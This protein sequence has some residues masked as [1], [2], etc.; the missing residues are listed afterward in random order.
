MA[1]VNAPKWIAAEVLLA[2]AGREYLWTL[3]P[4][5]HQGDVSKL[6]GACL[7]LVLLSAVGRVYRQSRELLA[8]LAV[9]AWYQLQ[10]MLCAAA[11]IVSPWP[12]PE[13]RGMCSARIDFDL[14][15][16]GLLAVAWVAWRMT[17]KLDRTSGG[18]NG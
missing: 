16:L 1:R 9:G 3:A 5:E 8:V 4:A 2:I 15:A 17:V 7:A 6:L 11:Y 14:G 12:I 18:S 10:T 13:G